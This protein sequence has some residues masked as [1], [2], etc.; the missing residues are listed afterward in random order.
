MTMSDAERAL[1]KILEEPE[2]TPDS[3]NDEVAAAF[4]ELSKEDR[5]VLEKVVMA[6]MPTPD[7]I[8][9]A[10]RVAQHNAKVESARREKLSRRSAKRCARRKSRPNYRGR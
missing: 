10:E 5:R 8:A 1:L 4:P 3:L 7:E 9:L 2:I 6:E